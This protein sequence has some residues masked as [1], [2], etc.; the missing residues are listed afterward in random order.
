MGVSACIEELLGA[1]R[2]GRKVLVACLNP[3]SYVVARGRRRFQDALRAAGVLLPDGVGILAASR[4]L[5]GSVRERVTG[6]ELFVGLNGGLDQNGGG[7]TFLLGATSEVLQRMAERM[8]TEWPRVE[9][10]GR[11]APPYESEFSAA[12]KQEMVAQV[13]AVRPDV[14]WIGMTAPKQEELALDILP[15]LDVKI[16][17]CVGAVFDFYAG[18]VRRASRMLRQAGLEWLPRL[19]REPRRLWRRTVIS[20][21]IF[22]WN[23]A[24]ACIRGECARPAPPVAICAGGFGLALEVQSV[25]G[26]SRRG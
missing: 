21:P 24:R 3:H 15:H 8:R 20:G 26:G 9:I 10:V 2:D 1:A 5:R 6:H 17:G 4:I 11:Y 14:L 19:A 7:S 25:A 18:T 12:Q 13:S 23:V 22:V 16:V